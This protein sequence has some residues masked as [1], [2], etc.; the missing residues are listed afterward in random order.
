M[1]TQQQVLDAV[2]SGALKSHTADG[3]DFL[4]LL[5]FFPESYF[6]KFGF[7]VDEALPAYKHEPVPW[8]EQSIKDQLA[9]DVA[10]GFEKAL[11][12]RG[13][14]ASMMHATVRMWMWILEDPLEQQAE[15]LYTQYG[16]PFFKAVAVKYGFPN[17]IGDHV[18]NEFQ[19]SA[20]DI[21][22]YVEA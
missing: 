19:Y 3:R 5:A 12:K 16:L 10:F 9:K 6:I 15:G 1:L 22:G 18:G 13:I 14:S 21:I 11:G 8:T 20:E 17:P 7:K 4:R 2:S